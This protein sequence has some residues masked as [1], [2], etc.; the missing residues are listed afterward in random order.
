MEPHVHRKLY[1]KVFVCMDTTVIVK[2]VSA[3]GEEEVGDSLS[4]AAAQLLSTAQNGPAAG[5]IRIVN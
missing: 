1:E 4:Q 2:A 3:L 5:L